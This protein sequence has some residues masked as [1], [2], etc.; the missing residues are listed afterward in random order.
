MLA[1]PGP[2]L[3]PSG[4]EGRSLLRAELLK[5]QYHDQHLVQRLL[6]WLGRLF[7]RSVGAATGSSPATVFL[8]MLLAALLVVGFALLVTR[9]R[10]DSRVRTRVG[11]VLPDDR[12]SASA[13]RHRAE[14]AL[15]EERYDDAVLDA[16]RAL[17]A[18]QIERRELD[19]QPGMTAH[20]VS[21]RL[22]AAH[23]PLADDLRRGADR[24][25]ATLYGHRPATREHAVTV[26]ALDDTLVGAR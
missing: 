8:T 24:F 21:V 17:T 9:V 16:F 14:E 10:R 23:P 13:L 12:P 18:R 26:L 3:A 4:D 1:P 7:E 22:A 20:E 2:P 5:K 6:G 19:D 15:R 11:S 25:D